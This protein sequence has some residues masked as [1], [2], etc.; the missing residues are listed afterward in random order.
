MERHA[1]EDRAGGRD[2]C[3]DLAGA[4]VDH[5]HAI[6]VGE[7]VQPAAVRRQAGRENAASGYRGGAE[8]PIGRHVDERDRAFVLVAHVRRPPVGAHADLRRQVPYRERRRERGRGEVRAHRGGGQRLG[9]IDHTRWGD[10]D[11]ER[12]AVQRH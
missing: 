4:R 5:V 9:D 11:G 2:L 12:R 1:R 7:R 10:G 6:V 3:H 8:R